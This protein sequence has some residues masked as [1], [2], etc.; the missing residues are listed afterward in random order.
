MVQ[1]GRCCL[2][3]LTMPA[4]HCIEIEPECLNV[5]QARGSWA[6]GSSGKGSCECSGGIPGSK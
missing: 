6:S 3:S 2:S 1:V 5:M 4:C